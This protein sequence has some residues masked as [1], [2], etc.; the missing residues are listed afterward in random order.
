MLSQFR[1]RVWTLAERVEDMQYVF[2]FF[3]DGLTS[4]RVGRLNAWRGE[5]GRVARGRSNVGRKHLA[6]QRWLAWS[7]S[8]SPSY[9]V[10]IGGGR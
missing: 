9:G 7:S 4:G 10:M 1:L 6:Y 3:E 5:S 2:S 8:L